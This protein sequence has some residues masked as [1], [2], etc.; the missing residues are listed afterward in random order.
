MR[1]APSD[2]TKSMASMRNSAATALPTPPVMIREAKVMTAIVID[3][4]DAMS[5]THARPLLISGGALPTDDPLD[6]HSVNID[7]G[8]AYGTRM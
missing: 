1:M 5:P 7:V 8:P 6:N 2:W 4:R 3:P